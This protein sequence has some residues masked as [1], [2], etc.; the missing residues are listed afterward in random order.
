MLGCRSEGLSVV[1]PRTWR[2][3]GDLI[4]RPG[5]YHGYARHREWFFRCK[6]YRRG[7]EVSPRDVRKFV[8]PSASILLTTAN[9]PD[10]V[11]EYAA[12]LGVFVMDRK[13]L[14]A[15]IDGLE[16]ARVLAGEV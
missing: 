8:H 6:P 5:D 13:R 9:A 4:A 2:V 3:P 14:A 11:R 10:P 16:L 12:D 7:K 15:W 1:L